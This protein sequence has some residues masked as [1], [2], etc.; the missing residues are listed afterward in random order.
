MQAVDY[1]ILIP[2]FVM[3]AVFFFYRARIKEAIEEFSDNLPR[4]GPPVPM[5]PS[6]AGDERL[7]RKPRRADRRSA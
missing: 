6:P 2:A 7:L 1:S 3:G 5:H 4:G